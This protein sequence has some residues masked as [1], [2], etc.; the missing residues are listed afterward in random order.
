MFKWLGDALSSI[1]SS[2]GEGVASL[3]SWLFSG[4]ISVLTKV[5]RAGEGLWDLLGAILD[6]FMS[7][8]DAITGLI[9]AFFPFVP[10][11]VSAVIVAGLFAVLIAGIIKWK[12]G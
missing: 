6:F 5:V 9:P 11:E 3:L 1:G 8:I 10:E 12:K 4:L 7:V 2:V